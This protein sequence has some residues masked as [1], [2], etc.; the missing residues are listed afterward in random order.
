MGPQGAGE[1]AVGPQRAG[2]KA[3]GPQRAGEKALGPQRQLWEKGR[4]VLVQE[5]SSY[6]LLISRDQC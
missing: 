4:S 6:F 2:E 1:K 3:V 5:L